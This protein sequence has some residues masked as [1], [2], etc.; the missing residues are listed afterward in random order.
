MTAGAATIGPGGGAAPGQTKIRWPLGSIRGNTSPAQPAN[1]RH[2]PTA[3][4]SAA[5]N[6][7]ARSAP[8]ALCPSLSVHDHAVATI[9][10]GRLWRIEVARGLLARMK[11]TTGI[12]RM[13]PFCNSGRFAAATT[14]R[15]NR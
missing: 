14:A 2:A 10:L 7:A 4:V 1:N 6:A 3:L 9:I 13:L 15:R 5:R 8:A 12:G 11:F